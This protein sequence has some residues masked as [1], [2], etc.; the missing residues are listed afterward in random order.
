[1]VLVHMEQCIVVFLLLIGTIPAENLKS[2]LVVGLCSHGQGSSQ[3][4]L[5]D[6]Q[7][8]TKVMGPW[9]TS[10]FSIYQ[11]WQVCAYVLHRLG[12]DNSS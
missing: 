9:I 1:M 12:D 11:P 7:T 10:W 5:V 4:T 2:L 8:H 6:A 3:E